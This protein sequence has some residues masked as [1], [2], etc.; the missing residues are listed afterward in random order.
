MKDLFEWKIFDTTADWMDRLY[1]WDLENDEW[2]WQAVLVVEEWR[3]RLY[4]YKYSDWYRNEDWRHC[5]EYFYNFEGWLDITSLGYVEIDF[6][7]IENTTS[8]IVKLC[9]QELDSNINWH[10]SDVE[11]FLEKHKKEIVPITKV[12]NYYK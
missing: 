6:D 9:Q 2:M 11:F 10:K 3:V 1:L 12:Y 4:T 5:D 7:T 8:D